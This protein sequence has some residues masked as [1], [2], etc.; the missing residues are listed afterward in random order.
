MLTMDEKFIICFVPT[1]ASWINSE[2]DVMPTSCPDWSQS[3][4]AVT[5]HYT[6]RSLRGS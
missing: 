4:R 1:E 2:C 6:T 3:Y 5:I